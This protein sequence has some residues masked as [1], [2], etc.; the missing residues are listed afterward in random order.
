[1]HVISRKRLTDFTKN[2]AD[3][4]GQMDTLYYTLSKGTFSTPAAIKEI[5]GTADFLPND[6]VVFNIKGNCYRIV[7]GINY[8][9]GTVFIKFVGTHAEYSKINARTI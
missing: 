1:M 6:R 5:F 2:H 4:K 3:T 7:V 8:G 9:N